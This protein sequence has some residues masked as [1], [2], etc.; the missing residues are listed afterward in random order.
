MIYEEPLHDWKTLDEEGLRKWAAQYVGWATNEMS[1]PD[2]LTWEYTEQFPMRDFT[3]LCVYWEDFYREEV[4]ENPR[5]DHEFEKGQWHTPVVISI[6]MDEIIIWD[7]WHRIATSFHRKDEVI[8]AIIGRP[9]RT[10]H[11]QN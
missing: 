2:D 5:Y 1:D 6:E 9:K 7:G 8:M 4:L 3:S 11:E 10:T